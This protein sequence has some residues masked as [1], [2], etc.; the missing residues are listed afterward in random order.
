MSTS[1]IL[2]VEDNDDDAYLTLRAF[3]EAKVHNPI[4]RVSDGVQALD[5]LTSSMEDKDRLAAYDHFANSYVQK[6]ADYEQFVPATRQLRL[7]WM[8]LNVGPTD[9]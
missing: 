4:I 3:K 8:V 2:L 9:R 5:F 1:T 6:P 7:Y